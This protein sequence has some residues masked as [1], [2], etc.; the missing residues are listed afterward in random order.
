MLFPDLKAFSVKGPVKLNILPFKKMIIQCFDATLISFKQMYVPSLD[1][2]KKLGNYGQLKLNFT[3]DN[4]V[5]FKYTQND[6]LVS[7]TPHLNLLLK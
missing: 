5:D 3:E 1:S 6:V 4:S 7:G 2:Q